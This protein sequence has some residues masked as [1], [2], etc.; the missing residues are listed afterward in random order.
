MF[1]SV[2]LGAFVLVDARNGDGL[3]GFRRAGV[4]TRAAAD[5]KCWVHLRQT[6]VVPVGNGID[7]L[8]GAMF[9]TGSAIGVVK[10]NNAVV[11]GEL[12]Q[13]DAS[14]LFL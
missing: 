2:F 5:A 1:F 7:G 4:F 14:D 10:F 13:P 12:R 3:S 11:S 8:G 9:R 6:Q